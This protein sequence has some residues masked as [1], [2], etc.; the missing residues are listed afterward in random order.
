MQ[1]KLILEF[2]SWPENYPNLLHH[3]WI[4]FMYK[5]AIPFLKP[6]FTIVCDVQK[7][8]RQNPKV[9]CF[10]PFFLF[11]K[12]RKC[13]IVNWDVHF[14]S[15]LGW[16][17]ARWSSTCQGIWWPGSIPSTGS[18]GRQ[19]EKLHLCLYSSQQSW[20][21]W[22]TVYILQTVKVKFREVVCLYSAR[23]L[24]ECKTKHVSTE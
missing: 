9:R 2:I 19:K 6:G 24:C 5:S 1:Y 17:V 10:S 4:F 14:R 21:E 3:G 7:R 18:K 16:V 23:L 15:T 8:T 12:S 20:E 22:N 13:L 11:R